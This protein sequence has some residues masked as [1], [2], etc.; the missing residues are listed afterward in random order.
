MAAKELGP[1]KEKKLP[2]PVRV[3]GYINESVLVC[4]I[5]SIIDSI[6]FN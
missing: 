6:Q 3:C 2:R 1:L 5:I 4:Y